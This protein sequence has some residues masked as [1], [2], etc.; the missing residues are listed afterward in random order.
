MERKKIKK[1]DQVLVIAGKDKGKTGKVEKVLPQKDKLIIG[2]VNII[3]KHVKASRKNPKGGIIEA[4]API[5]LSNVMLL[6]PK[7]HKPT[8]VGL[9]VLNKTKER[10]CKRCQEEI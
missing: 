7:C 9:K 10:I 6:C 1:G 5:F 3:K 8:R 4:S 2:G